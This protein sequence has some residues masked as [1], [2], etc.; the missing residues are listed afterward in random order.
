MLSTYPLEPS[1]GSTNNNA[2]TF[3][4][5]GPTGGF[6]SWSNEAE[7]IHMICSSA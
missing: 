7:A 1:Q 6:G 4:T 3:Q 5:K 2:F